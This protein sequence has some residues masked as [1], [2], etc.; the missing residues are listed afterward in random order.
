MNECVEMLYSIITPDIM[1]YFVLIVRKE[2]KENMIVKRKRKER[3]GEHYTPDA[4]YLHQ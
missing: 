2:K 4:F 1:Y 3:E